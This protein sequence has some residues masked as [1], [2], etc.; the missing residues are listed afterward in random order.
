M[1]VVK[2]EVVTVEVV[3]ETVVELVGVETGMV[4]ETAVGVGVESVEV[5]TRMAVEMVVVVEAVE[6]EMAVERAEEVGVTVRGGCDGGCRVEGNKVAKAELK[7]TIS[8]PGVQA[9]FVLFEM[10]KLSFLALLILARASGTLYRS[11]NI[12]PPRTSPTCSH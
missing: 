6:A 11:V 8:W 3:I 4:L 2:V 9:G 5:E 7:E 1:V 10:E 12:L